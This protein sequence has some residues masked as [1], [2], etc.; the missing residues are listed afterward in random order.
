MDFFFK[1]YAVKTQNSQST[2]ILLCGMWSI[3]YSRLPQEKKTIH[4]KDIVKIVRKEPSLLAINS[5]IPFGEGYRK[6]LMRIF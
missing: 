1:S 5:K 3:F 4:I 6:S 2:Q